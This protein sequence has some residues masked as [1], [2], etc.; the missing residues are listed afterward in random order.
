MTMTPRGS[1]APMWRALPRPIATFQ[2]TM[3]VSCN[4]LESVKT[5][6]VSPDA[7]I[8]TMKVFEQGGAYESDYLAAIEDAIILVATR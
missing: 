1:M 3:G 6:G 7:Q 4:A 8:I 5:Q 2:T